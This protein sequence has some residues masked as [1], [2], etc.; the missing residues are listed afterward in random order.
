MFSIFYPYFCLG[1][2]RFV[3]F[4]TKPSIL[5]PVHVLTKTYGII[6]IH[7][8]KFTFSGLM[9]VAYGRGTELLS[10]IS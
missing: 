4:Y 3:I 6:P 9:E 7:S 8:Q 10:F 5:V 2:S 1:L